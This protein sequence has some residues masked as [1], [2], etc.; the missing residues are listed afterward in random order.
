MVKFILGIILGV[1]AIIFVM[2]NTDMV[3]VRFLAW[4]LEMSRAL[5]LLVT[6]AVGAFLGW[7]FA[8]FSRRRRVRK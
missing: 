4:Q 2:Q 7:V 3:A 8:T 5:L 6:L 1:A